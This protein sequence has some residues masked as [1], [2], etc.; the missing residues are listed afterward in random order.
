MR[1]KNGKVMDRRDFLRGVATAA[2]AAGFVGTREAKAIGISDGLQSGGTGNPYGLPEGL[3]PHPEI[4]AARGS[5][6]FWTAV[7]KSFVLPENYIH[8]N[9]GTTGSQPLFSLNNLAAYN[10]YKSEDP[11]D[12]QANLNAD[13]GDLF[14]HSPTP[15]SETAIAKRQQ[16]IAAQYGANANEIV[17]SY[18]TTD[19]CNLIFAGTPWEPGDRIVTTQ[20]EHNAMVGPIAWARDYRGVEIRIVY[21]P[22]NFT[23]SM[24]KSD[25]LSLFEKELKKPLKTGNKQYAAFSE[26]FYKNGLRMPVK[27]LNALAKSYGAY[28]IVDSAHGWGQ[29]PVNCHDY[30]VDF[31]CGAGH[32]WLCGGPGT[33]IFYIRYSGDNL[34]PFA[35]GN[36]A[37][38]GNLFTIPS[39]WYDNRNSAP[40]AMQG[41]GEANTPA[42]YAMTDS[43]AFF[44]YVGVQDI[45]AR[46]VALGSYLKQKIEAHW[47]PEALWVQRNPDPS[48][49]TFLTAFNPFAGRND[50]GQFS[51]MNSKMNT[52]LSTLSSE[53]PKIYIRTITW[54]DNPGST[55]DDRIGFR[56]STHAMYNNFEQIDWMFGRLVAAVDATGLP[57]LG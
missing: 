48:F 44:N 55:S 51:T 7:R 52:V 5:E 24:T 43:A 9:T 40:S 15:Q 16:A 29:L 22:S 10:F 23:A 41:R 19:A 34:P 30:G 37:A 14:P 39:T 3:L 47:G 28:T 11:R 53:D 2:L 27:E 32:K 25:I 54:R 57:Q 12:W 56:V 6:G 18:N 38:Y 13:F 17:L 36:W 21:L 50:A 26:I 35:R 8:M 33:G 46:G 1:M 31:L 4:T 42:L 49:A 45:Y 20:L